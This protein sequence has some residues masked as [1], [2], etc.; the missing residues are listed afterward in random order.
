MSPFIFFI[1]MK[2]LLLLGCLLLASCIDY[3]PY[4]KSDM[5]NK[6]YQ[7]YKLDC[8]SKDLA[9]NTNYYGM[10]EIPLTRTTDG[11]TYNE[12]TKIHDAY[13]GHIL[14]TTSPIDDAWWVLIEN[15]NTVYCDI[16]NVQSSIDM[17]GFNAGDPQGKCVYISKSEQTPNAS[18]CPKA[19]DNHHPYEF[20][21][22]TDGVYH[23]VEIW[24]YDSYGNK[25]KCK[26]YSTFDYNP[27]KTY[28]LCIEDLGGDCLDFND[29]VILGGE[30]MK[31]RIIFRMAAYPMTIKAD[32][33]EY[34]LEGEMFGE[35][36]IE[37]PFNNMNTPSSWSNATIIA[38]DV[39]IPILLNR[40]ADMPAVIATDITY[41]FHRDEN[42]MTSNE[43]INI[44]FW[45]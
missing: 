18:G 27:I 34:K 25:I 28:L 31:P 22:L 4:S 30:N 24:S 41:Q 32:N 5:K 1:F 13:T 40:I 8:I 23:F 33:Q 9:I 42:T 38:D 10:G 45:K 19:H 44:P 12:W 6:E 37:L 16:N 11:G 2:N 7:S 29:C 39:T 14:R 20:V 15:S 36:D 3:S 35:Y 26:V 17:P 43:F 21:H